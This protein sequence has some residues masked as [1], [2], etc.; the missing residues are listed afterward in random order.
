MLTDALAHI[1]H[2]NVRSTMGDGLKTHSIARW[3]NIVKDVRMPTTCA[4]LCG[5]R[6]RR[7]MHVIGVR[8]QTLLKSLGYLCWYAI[9][10]NQCGATWVLL[11]ALNSWKSKLIY[12]DREKKSGLVSLINIPI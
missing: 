9:D 4:G 11:T 1:L 12:R 7:S 8:R 10:N 2:S 3:L 6:R 5:L